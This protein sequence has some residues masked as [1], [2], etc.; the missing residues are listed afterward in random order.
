MAEVMLRC[1]D[2]IMSISDM[3]TAIVMYNFVYVNS[4]VLISIFFR[5]W[6]SIRG[7]GI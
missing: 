3:M 7:S 6:V 2:Y 1:N 5:S 4:V